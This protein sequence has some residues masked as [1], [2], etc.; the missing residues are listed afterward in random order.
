LTKKIINAKGYNLI[1]T[2]GNQNIGANHFYHMSG[3]RFTWYQN[4]L[5]GVNQHLYRDYF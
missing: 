4:H 3:Y 1:A 5:Q 2:N